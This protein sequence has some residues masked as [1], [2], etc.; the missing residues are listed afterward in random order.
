M[1]TRDIELGYF[2]HPDVGEVPGVVLIHDVWGLK[3]H[4]RDLSRRLATAGYGVLAVDLYRHEPGF[5]IEDPGVWMRA[6]SDPRALADVQAAVD[7]LRDEPVTGDLPVGVI[8]FCMGGMYALLAACSCEG[9]SAA[10]P[11]YGLLSHSHGMLYADEG[12]DPELKPREP[13]QAAADLRCPL[14]GVFG[15]RDD[16]VPMSDIGI[17]ERVLEE[18]GQSVEVAVY[19]EAGHAFLNDTRPDAFRP[20]DA[21]HAWRRM[22]DFLSTHLKG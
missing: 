18:T 6:L 16:F 5:E 9:V 1:Q 14:L 15:G 10:V 13:L 19:P 22:L 21:E 17:L 7:W 8:G 20:D 2:A 3:D 4:T 11:F 12:L